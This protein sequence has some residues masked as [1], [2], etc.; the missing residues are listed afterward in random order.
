MN[1]YKT[2]NFISQKRRE[3]NLTQEQLAEQLNVSNKTISKWETGRCMPDYS[4]VQN[5]CQKL[6]ITVAELMDGEENDKSIRTYDDDQVIEML[7]RIQELEKNKAR[8]NNISNGL[9]LLIILL[10]IIVSLQFLSEGF[11]GYVFHI[12]LIFALIS[13]LIGVFKPI[14]KEKLNKNKD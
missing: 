13:H 6:K 14:I 4:I 12:Y 8:E 10:A 7:R 5:L 9:L 2:G 11:I 3:Q 1:Q